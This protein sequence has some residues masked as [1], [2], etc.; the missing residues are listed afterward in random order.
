MSVADILRQHGKWARSMEFTGMIAKKFNISNREAYRK[1]KQA[2]KDKEIRRLVDPGLGV[3]YGL[4]EWPFLPKSSKKPKETLSFQE[5]FL[6]RCFNKLDQIISANLYSNSLSAYYDLRSFI[7]TLPSPIKDKLR[8]MIKK[9]DEALRNCK[10]EWVRKKRLIP[11]LGPAL[12]NSPSE[13]VRE[14]REIR[15]IQELVSRE[16]ERKAIAFHSVEKLVDEIS[17][18][19]HEQLEK[20]T[21]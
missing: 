3:F 9:T 12:L 6:H 21:P 16:S 7:W 17:S 5:V 14:K 10:D 15:F 4:P 20:E 18:F 11:Q 2:W 8:P 19:L 1:S 13:V